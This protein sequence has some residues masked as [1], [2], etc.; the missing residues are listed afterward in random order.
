MIS[1]YGIF[2][3]SLCRFCAFLWRYQNPAGGV[4]VAGHG[5]V[6]DVGGE[7]VGAHSFGP[8][9]HDDAFFVREEI[10]EVDGVGGTGAF[11]E[12]IE[13]EMIELQASGVR[14]HQSERGARDVF[15]CDAECRTDTFN[16]DRLACPERTT[17]QKDLTAFETRPDL[18]PIV[19]RLLGR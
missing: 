4:A 15:L 8:L 6:P 17:E 12:T 18:M 9:D 3:V 16:K 14:V 10:V 11:V 5:Y 13:I 19:E 1:E 2:Q 7:G